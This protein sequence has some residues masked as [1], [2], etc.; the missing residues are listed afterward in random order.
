MSSSTTCLVSPEDIGTFI[1]SIENHNC[2]PILMEEG[3][4]LG[5]LIPVQSSPKIA[6]VE[7][8]ITHTLSPRWNQ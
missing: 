6:A 7:Y 2:F 3:Q 4:L 5:T 1:M 8:I